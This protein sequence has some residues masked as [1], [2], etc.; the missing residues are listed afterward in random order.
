[1]VIGGLNWMSTARLVRGGFLSVIEQTFVQA[2]QA[3]GAKPSRVI[4]QHI[5]PNTIGPVIV[6]ATLAVGNAVLAEATLSFL[7]LGFPPDVP[8]W[9]RML[10]SAQDYLETAPHM[11]LFPGASIFL[12]V[13]SIN[14]VGDGLRD[15][16]DVRSTSTSKL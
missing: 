8:T 12:T 6:A 1:V 2:V 15:T 7:G 11:A 10:A 5:L 16:F 3:L 9:G 4:W 14:I 13:L